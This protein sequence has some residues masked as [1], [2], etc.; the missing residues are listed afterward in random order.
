VATGFDDSDGGHVDLGDV[1]L[2]V[3]DAGPRDG[4]LVVLVHGFPEL[5]FSWRHQIGPL[6]E[7]GYRVLVPDLRG[8]GRSDRPREVEAYAIGELAGDVVGLVDHA[9]AERAV[10]VGHDWGAD[11]AWKTAWMHPE[12]VAAVAGLSVPFIPRAPAPPVGLMRQFLGEDFYIVWFQEPGA[13]E[14]VLSRDVRRTMATSRVWNAAW[15]AEEELH[16]PTPPF[17][18]D[19]ELAR[20]VAAYERTGFTGGLNL[21]RNLDRNW[22]RTEPYADRR[23]EQPA[24]Y[25]VGE[26]DPVKDFMPAAAMEGW[27][28]DLRAS[29]V[30]PGAGHWVNQEAPGEVNA[31][32]LGWLRE[33]APA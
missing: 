15:E 3:L 25:L 5:A 28:T 11:I 19:E 9:G 23:V 18:T 22:E 16:P 24:L 26:R 30:V 10:V 21:Y 31:A 29:V 17:M 7:A 1:R 6:T 14:E 12:R 33:V 2:W 32:L 8:A 13:A 20:Y 4:P 27:V